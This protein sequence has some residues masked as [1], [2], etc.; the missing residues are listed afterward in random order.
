MKRN[1]G[2]LLLLLVGGSFLIWWW[3]PRTPKDPRSAENPKPVPSCNVGYQ[4]IAL[5]RHVFVA[6]AKGFFKEESIEVNL[7]S[8]ASANQLMQA[9][10]AGD[11][12]A[13]GLS[14]FEVALSV[15]GKDPDRFELVNVLLWGERS[16]P[17]FILVRSDGG[18][19]GFKELEGRTIGVH[20]GSATGAFSRTVLQKEGVD[21]GKCNFIEVTP[22]T[23]Q[24]TV[25]AKRVDAL[26]CMDPV[27]TSLLE[28]KQCTVLLAN[29]LAKLFDPPIPISGTALSKKFLRER[30]DYARRVVRALEKAIRYL[31]EPGH[32]K[33]VADYIAK[34]TPIS[35]ELATRMNPSEYWTLAEID[36][37][38]V[39]AL[40]DRFLELK[41][42]DKHVN[43]ED[44]IVPADYLN[45]PDAGK[46]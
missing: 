21:I 39:Q 36:R 22:A 8:F 26:Y 15:E 12:D 35:V 11:L 1:L 3:S 14:N 23:M 27:A 10:I 28:T 2:F 44:F 19:S 25:V 45:P 37:K 20:P 17:D 5:Y 38:R 29:P 6:Q 46:R 42:V 32:E 7:R 31:R 43:V 18:I 34:Y 4:E 30:P 40:A 41:I 33:E 16:Y 24:A 13:T 9:L